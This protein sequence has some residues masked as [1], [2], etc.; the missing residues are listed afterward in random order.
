MLET[1]NLSHFSLHDPHILLGRHHFD[2][3]HDVFVAYRPG[4]QDCYI[5]LDAELVMMQRSSQS[6]F[7]I[8]KIPKSAKEIKVYHASGLLAHD[9]YCFH[10][11]ISDVD[12]YLFA[13]GVH[14]KLYELLGSHIREINGIKGVYFAVWA[15][16]CSSVHLMADFNHFCTDT[17]PMRALGSSGI[18]ELFVPGIQA[19]EK[20]KYCLTTAY[21]EK[22]I[23]TDPYAHEFELRPKNAAVVNESRFQFQD[24]EYLDRRKHVNALNQPINCYELHLGSWKKGLT[25]KDAAFELSSY[26]KQMGYTHI[27]LL[28]VMEHPLD[29]SWGYQVTGFFAP[30]SRYGN[31]DDFKFF[32]NHLHNEGIGVILDW[33]PAHFPSDD[34]ALARFDGTS[35]YEHHDLKKG[36][37]PHWNTLIFNYGRHEVQNFLIASAL[38]WIEECH[39]DGLRVDA[40]ASMLYLDYGRKEGEWIPNQHGGKENLEAIEFLKHL[41]SIVHRRCQGALMI[42]EE[43]TSFAHVTNHVDYDGL[44]FDLKWNMGWMNDTLRYFS[45]DPFYRKYHQNLLT[46]GLLYAFSEKFQYVLSHDEVVHGKKSLLSKMPGDLWQKFANLRLLLCYMMTQPGKKLLFMGGEL[47]DYEEWNMYRSLSWHL[48][49]NPESAGLK[50]L[51]K[52]LN[53]LYKNKKALHEK[54]HDHFGFEWVSLNDCANSVISYLRKSEH[55][56]LFCILHFTPQVL[57]NYDVYLPYGKKLNLILNSDDQAY[58]GSSYPLHYNLEKLEGSDRI[59]ATLTLPPLA[60]LIFEVLP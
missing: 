52:T 11:L 12:Q 50:H 34:F 27:Q 6:G 2:D 25:F 8:E 1:Y 17:N 57:E 31:L 49:S 33:V 51:V 16:S 10:S 53:H 3:C 13:K 48:L 60:C 55:E 4:F 29:E 35:L 38:F 23:K 9:P 30:S 20:Y 7:F 54:D 24:H 39:V 5:Q 40:V 46:F 58:C 15:P 44:G 32:V 47:G 59:K 41:N 43:S 56:T 18:W 21:G 45:H 37:H 28:P 42:A 22:L 26:A 19:G 36:F 14:Y